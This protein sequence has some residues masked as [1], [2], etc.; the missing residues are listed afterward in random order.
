MASISVREPAVAGQFY[1]AQPAQ[2]KREV[3]RYISDASLPAELGTVRAV[4]TP[5]A[6]YVYSGN[7]A[8]YAFK[9]LEQHSSRECTV[10]LMGPAHRVPVDGVALGSY[11]AFRTPLGEAPVAVERVQAMLE[12]SSIYIR[13]P[14]AHVH[15]H[16]L[17]VVVPFLQTAL[18]HFRLIPMLFGRAEPGKVGDDLEGRVGKDDL[19]V[20]STDLSHFYPDD[21]ARDLDRDF[22]DAVLESDEIQATKG[23]ACGLAPVR[24]LMRVADRRGWKAHLLDYR[25]SAD[26][27]GDTSRVVGYAALAYVE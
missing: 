17:E 19:I 16:S 15:E 8:G 1:P 26:T 12:R 10:F 27:A 14:Q 5:H 21:A 18:P 25:T 4:M 13:A 9:S 2:L 7:T 22:L 24:A 20:V 3:R 11:S 23:E 6:G